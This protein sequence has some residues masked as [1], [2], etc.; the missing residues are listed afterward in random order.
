[1]K[2]RD[3]EY[4]RARSLDEALELLDRHGPD[5]RVIAGGQS[6]VPALAMRLAAPELLIDI[7]DIEELRG[8]RLVEHGRGRRLRI[9]GL[10]RHVEIESG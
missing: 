6:L 4:R 8:L 2:A 3:F 7:A 9:G 10:T 1:M 5:A